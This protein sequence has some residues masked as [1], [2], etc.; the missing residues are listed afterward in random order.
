MR[1]TR[2]MVVEEE[3]ARTPPPVPLATFALHGSRAVRPSPAYSVTVWASSSLP[4]VCTS[5]TESTEHRVKVFLWRLSSWKHGHVT[6]NSY[7][8]RP[9]GQ[10]RASPLMSSATKA[11]A[12]AGLAGSAAA[13]SGLAPAGLKPANGRLSHQRLQLRNARPTKVHSSPPPARRSA[14]LWRGARPDRASAAPA[15]ACC[16]RSHHWLVTYAACERASP[17][18]LVHDACGHAARAV[19]ALRPATHAMPGKPA[20]APVLRMCLCHSACGRLQRCAWLAW[21]ASWSRKCCDA[22][23]LRTLHLKGRISAPSRCT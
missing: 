2:P 17:R 7:Q 11:F 1:V 10:S 22:R 21:C 5:S 13:F 15:H 3:P 20:R 14:A 12:L 23:C 16:Q 4:K 9:Q 18:D 19:V 8:R 6:R